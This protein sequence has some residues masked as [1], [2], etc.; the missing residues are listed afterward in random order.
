MKRGTGLMTSG[1]YSALASDSDSDGSA[2]QPAPPTA[3][4]MFGRRPE[5]LAMQGS[6]HKLAFYN[7]GWQPGSKNTLLLG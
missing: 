2:A 4:Y 7:V 5:E 1:C 6:S 3:A